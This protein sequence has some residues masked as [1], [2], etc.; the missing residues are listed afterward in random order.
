MD[1]N[2]IPPISINQNKVQKKNVSSVEK[3]VQIFGPFSSF[4]PKKVLWHF[5][6]NP[7]NLR[8]D[9]RSLF[10]T[11]VQSSV[12]ADC[13]QVRRKNSE[14]TLITLIFGD[15]EQHCEHKFRDS[16]LFP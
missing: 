13:K 6:Q 7:Y 11:C 10:S 5:G 2:F 4:I 15:Q 1:S 16:A 8:I 3:Y 9:L 12:R 14:I